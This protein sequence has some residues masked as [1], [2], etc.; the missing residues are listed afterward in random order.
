M[1]AYAYVLEHLRE[2]DCARL[3]AYAD[4]GPASFSTWL[5]V[6]ARRLCVDWQR[7]RYGRVGGNESS[8]MASPVRRRLEDLISAAVDPAALPESS[9]RSPDNDLLRREK[10]DALRAA[11]GKLSSQDRLL[12]AL[13]F[14]DDQSA[15]RIAR[16]LGFPTPFH[17][18]RRL[19]ALLRQLKGDLQQGGIDSAG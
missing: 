5:V 2:R 3:R 1:D 7:T 14:E 16:L 15:A 6:V 17:V 10:D 18:Y 8:P 11:L 13:R 19:D 4:N 12:L 9:E